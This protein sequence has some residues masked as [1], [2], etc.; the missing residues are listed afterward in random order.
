[1]SSNL[2][3]LQISDLPVDAKHRLRLNSIRKRNGQP[4]PLNNCLQPENIKKYCFL[5]TFQITRVL[6]H[7]YFKS[8][9]FA[10][11]KKPAKT[12]WGYNDWPMRIQNGLQICIRWLSKLFWLTFTQEALKHWFIPYEVKGFILVVS[13]VYSVLQNIRFLQKYGNV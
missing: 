8:L 10:I 11:F 3:L 2:R 13:T 12:H 9:K 6:H 5:D 4:I 7:F 1:M